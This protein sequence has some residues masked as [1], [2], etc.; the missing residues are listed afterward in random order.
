MNKIIQTDKKLA[1]SKETSGVS[2]LFSD[3]SFKYDLMND[4]MS[5]GLHRIWK[6]KF[7]S[8]IGDLDS[9]ILD[10]ASGTGDIVIYLNNKA[11]KFGYSP[12]IF[13]CDFN[14]KMLSIAKDRIFDFNMSNVNFSLEDAHKISFK[15]DFFDYYLVSFGIRNFANVELALKESLRVLKTTGQFLCLE[16]FKFDNKY[17]QNFYQFYLFFILPK[18]GKI[19]SKK[20]YAYQYLSETIDNFYSKED[21]RNM[22]YD[23]GFDDVGYIDLFP[24]IVTIFYGYKS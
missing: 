21:F 20:E 3:V 8:M 24:G 9:K 7:V 6:K 12:E 16:F 4:L 10:M 23:V 13:A 1:S 17:F 19:V 5:L 11:S 22:L 14:D 2:Q 15:D 18:I